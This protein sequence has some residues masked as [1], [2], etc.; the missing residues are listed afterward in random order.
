MNRSAQGF[1]LVVVVVGMWFLGCSPTGPK[2][3]NTVTDIDGNVYH[4]VTIGSQ[5]WMVENLKTTRYND[6]TT[7]PSVTND[8]TWWALATPGYCWYHDSVSYG[9]TYGALY[10]WY[11]VATGKL[12][13]TGW[14]VATDADW[15]TLTAYVG[16]D[17]VAGEK[18][19]EAGT[20]HW[21]SPNMFPGV[22]PTPNAIGTNNYG[23]TALPGGF[24]GANGFVN[25][26]GD[27]YWW[28]AMINDTVWDRYMGFYTSVVARGEYDFN[29]RFGFSVRC[30]RDN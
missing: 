9:A 29:Y 23:F 18:L 2:S 15:T 1:L 19:K 30:V 16:G 20:A 22:T 27:A 3:A 26:G 25:V 14:H 11:A 12:A 6:G 17:S 21:F 10:N 8:T 5:V 24:R 13:P 28:T 7:I 4:T